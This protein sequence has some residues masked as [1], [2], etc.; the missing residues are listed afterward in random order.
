[1]SRDRRLVLAA[2]Y[3]T[4]LRIGDNSTAVMA[5]LPAMTRDLGLGPA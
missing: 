3:L 4:M 5:A 1:M 2:C